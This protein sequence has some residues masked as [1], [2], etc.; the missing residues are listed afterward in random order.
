MEELA[1]AAVE[2][3]LN[4]GAEFADIRIEDSTSTM[5]EI[6]DG[7][8]KR[9][10]A[11]HFKGAGVRAFVEGAWAFAQ[12][13]EL[14]PSGMRE[15]GASAARLASVTK[16]RAS[17]KF[18][19]DGPSF[20]GRVHYRVMT[21]FADIPIEDRVAFAK[22]IDDQARDFDRRIVTTRTVYSDLWMT[23]FVANSLGTEVYFENALPR[24]SSIPTA[25]DGTSRQGG[26]KTLGLRGGFEV[27]RTPEAQ[28]VGEEAAQLAV[29]LLSSKVAKGGISD[30]IMDP[31]LNGVM[32]HEAFGHA[33][34]A[35]NWPAHATVLEDRV[36][37][38]V[39]P[40]TLCLSD[41]PTLPGRRGS[42]EYDWEGTKTRKRHLVMNG[43]LTELL[44]SLETSS[45]LGME[46]NGAARAQSFMS[47][48]IPRMSNTFMEP[49]DWDVD[50]LIQ[51]TK[52][53]MILCDFNYGYT[54]PSK[55]Q[56]MFQASHGYLIENGERG[57]IIRDVSLAGQILE[58]LAKV[59]AVAKD[60]HLDAGSCG[61]NGQTVPD[62]S[63]GPHAR[64]RQVPVG[65]V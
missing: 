59:D 29:E 42:F 22:F 5:I 2:S 24:V 17:E 49:G 15:T 48:P 40:E 54:D 45:R 39:G 50:E 4:A 46:P 65:G 12:T 1:R 28:H 41:D 19:I 32:V 7:V 25:K 27:M 63:G 13:T 3:A 62:M 10:L 60:F 52:S 16:K 51:D 58:V 9:S 11:S 34:E 57:Q 30:V 14:T 8:T 31:V 37:T 43:V 47:V 20:R 56:F 64:I 38:Q 61:K 18:R 35:D 23:V 6:V 33:C 21:H 53:G 26:H 36:G 55:G 44:H